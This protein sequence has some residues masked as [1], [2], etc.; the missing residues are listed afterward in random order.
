MN[1][2][3]N[4]PQLLIPILLGIFAFTFIT[5][6]KILCPSNINWLLLNVDTA[7]GLYAWQFF[8]YTPI[9]QSPL[10]ANYPYGM[11]M[12]WAVIFAEPLFLFAFPFKLISKLLPT[13]FDET[14]RERSSESRSPR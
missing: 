11:G 4:F 6:G 1:K 9:L 5:G 14:R 2:L 7:G 12:G 3:K 13:S 8:R 10:G